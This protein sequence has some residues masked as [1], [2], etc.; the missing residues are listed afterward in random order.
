LA[1]IYL[2]RWP[3]TAQVLPLIRA[4]KDQLSEEIVYVNVSELFPFNRQPIDFRIVK[5]QELVL[6]EIPYL[7]IK[8]HLS[9]IL[10]AFRC[11]IS[12]DR[13]VIGF[14]DQLLDLYLAL[15]FVFIPMFRVTTY[16]NHSASYMSGDV[17]QN[18][19]HKHAALCLKLKLDLKILPFYVHKIYQYLKGCKTIVVK[20]RAVSSIPLL[21]KSP[22]PTDSQH[23]KTVFFLLSR[24]HSV[25]SEWFK[26]SNLPFSP[27]TYLSELKRVIRDLES[28]NNIVL[29]FHP[30][31]MLNSHFFIE[32]S[33][34]VSCAYLGF[35]PIFLK[36]YP[37]PI[38]ITHIS[39]SI[40]HATSITSCYQWIPSCYKNNPQLMAIFRDFAANATLKAIATHELLYV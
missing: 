13:L 23:N 11:L 18:R 12:R 32:L 5:Y 17:C 30:K 35:D 37:E 33:H 16:T 22:S 9:L 26:L 8:S 28:S 14:A 7:L 25:E 36:D 1:Y 19:W 27:N 40:H 6:Q 39:S 21:L 31:T 34:H 3:L 15:V 4:L 24:F 38:C 20:V 2:D 29:V 10:L